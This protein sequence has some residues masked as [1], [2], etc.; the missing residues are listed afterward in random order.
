MA[1]T[2]N[3]VSMELPGVD[4][5][6]IAKQVIAVEVSKALAMPEQALN[7]LVAAAMME[8]VGSDG[9]PSHY[10]DAK[11]YVEWAA[12]SAIRGAVLDIIN[13]KIETMKPRLAELI[14]ASLKR[15][16]KA[17]A[18][19]LSDDFVKASSRQAAYGFKL[20]ITMQASER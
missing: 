13:K 16:A 18:I 15:N 17:I 14:E 6:A 1:E 9:K 2:T 5:G 10:N 8:K 20:D 11:T 4:F 19:T 12:R 3:K 7:A